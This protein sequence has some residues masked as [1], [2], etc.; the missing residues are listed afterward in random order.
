MW[1][2]IERSRLAMVREEWR[3]RAWL[4]NKHTIMMYIIII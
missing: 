2:A 4:L 3:T 1:A